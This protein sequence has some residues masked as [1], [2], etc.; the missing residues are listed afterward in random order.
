MP[1]QQMLDDVDAGAQG[2][3]DLGSGNPRANADIDLPDDLL[4]KHGVTGTGKKTA[5]SA[6]ATKAPAPGTDDED[7]PDDGL[8]SELDRLL[9]TDGEDEGEGDE[10]GDEDLEALLQEDSEEEDEG[11]LEE[12]SFIPEF[13][14]EKFLKK[15]KDN[16]DVIA[17]YKSFQKDYTKAKQQL[18]AEREEWQGRL[19]KAEQQ[20]TQYNEFASKL[21]DD[22]GMRDFLVNVALHRS[23]VFQDAFDEAVSLNEDEGKRDA[24]LKDKK[25]RERE[26]KL[27]REEKQREVQRQQARITEI[28]SL[29]HRAAARLGL[30]SDAQVEV[31]EQYVANAIYAARAEGKEIDNVQVVE[32]VKAAAKRLGVSAEK[33]KKEA[34]AAERKRRQADARGKAKDA[35]RP[36][37]PRGGR[38]PAT[39][40][41][42]KKQTRFIS[43]D[44]L[45]SIVDQYFGS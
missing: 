39:K 26:E 45:D 10:E 11:E 43:E 34:E 25:L 20:Q 40:E 37:P 3:H 33:A 19:Q 27:E 17:A 38:S 6:P 18:S 5:S 1:L 9:S 15:Y 21:R 16:P 31:A 12:D 22:D 36:Q 8:D 4:D 28:E 23:K 24:Y 14:R 2:S 29:T 13:N 7:T 41:P 42:E 32:A 35:R 30:S 44:P